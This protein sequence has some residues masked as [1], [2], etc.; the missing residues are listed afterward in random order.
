[1]LCMKNPRLRVAEAVATV[2]VEDPSLF[3]AHQHESRAL[4]FTQACRDRCRTLGIRKQ[5]AKRRVEV[6]NEMIEEDREGY[7]SYRLVMT[8][9]STR[10]IFP[11]ILANDKRLFEQK[12]A[13]DAHRG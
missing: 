8:D 13:T 12:E 5:D 6:W 3:A 1:M 4:A 11:A 2:A 10:E 9:D 7:E